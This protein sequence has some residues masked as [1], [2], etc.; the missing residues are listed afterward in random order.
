[1]SEAATGSA[2]PAATAAE[3]G[4]EHERVASHLTAAAQALDAAEVAPEACHATAARLREMAAEVTAAGG[5][6]SAAVDLE[7]LERSLTVLEEKLFAALTAAAPEDLLVGLKE[8]A[9]RE[10]APYRSRMGAVQ[11]RQVERQFV[12]KQLL[13]S[14]NLP[15]LSLFYMSQ[16]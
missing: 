1:M 4:F 2:I 15:R 10:L 3:S 16:Q 5:G 9:A 8:H 12:Q 13:A 14:Y 7:V 6:K 11:M